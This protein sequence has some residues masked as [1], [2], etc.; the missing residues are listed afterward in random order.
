MNKKQLEMKLTEMVRKVLNESTI[1]DF[2]IKANRDGNDMIISLTI[3]N[4]KVVTSCKVPISDKIY[5]DLF[6]YCKNKI[7]SNNS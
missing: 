1:A 5:S 7:S 3:H 4:G 2:T 6:Y